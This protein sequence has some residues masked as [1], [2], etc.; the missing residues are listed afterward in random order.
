MFQS[1]DVDSFPVLLFTVIGN[2]VVVQFT[3]KLLLTQSLATIVL[4]MIVW[5]GISSYYMLT[6]YSMSDL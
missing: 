4:K 3:P 1:S 2:I 6:S 5:Y